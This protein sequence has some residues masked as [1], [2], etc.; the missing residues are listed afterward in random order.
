MATQKEGWIGSLGVVLIVIGLL[1]AAGGI[2][3]VVDNWVFDGTLLISDNAPP[4][5]LP[6]GITSWAFLVG[7]LVTIVVAWR[8]MVYPNRHIFL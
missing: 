8:F 3:G 5:L 4:P 7:G 1:F 6:Y 2:M